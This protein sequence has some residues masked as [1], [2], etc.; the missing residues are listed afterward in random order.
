[1]K[2]YI[3]A[4]SAVTVALGFSG[5]NAVDT[6]AKDVKPMAADEKV[7]VGMKKCSVDGKTVMV[8]LDKACPVDTK[9][10]KEGV[11]ATPKPVDINVDFNKDAKDAKEILKSETMKKVEVDKK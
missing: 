3:F 8:A 6:T 4:L 11:K 10:V 2:K 9:D 7:P 5:L 1:M